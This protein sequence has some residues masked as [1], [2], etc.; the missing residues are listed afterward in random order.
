MKTR[1][2]TIA[3]C[4]LATGGLV[5]SAYAASAHGGPG[6]RG[7]GGDRQIERMAER[8]DLDD[9]QLAS[10]RAIVDSYRDEQRA[11]RDQL[12][13]GRAQIRGLGAS[14]EYDEEAVRALAEVQGDGMAELI[15]LKAQM[16]SEIAAV[17]T[18]EQREAL[19][20]M[21]ERGGRGRGYRR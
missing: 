15:V 13:G 4:V 9:A 12:R 14:G 11:L 10:V 6:G 7:V 1:T 18:D 2:T 16:F 20:E 21:G 5:L 19:A 8:L 3:L 17:L